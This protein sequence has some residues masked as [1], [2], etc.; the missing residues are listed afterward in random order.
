MSHNLTIQGI[1]IVKNKNIISLEEC[2]LDNK[3]LYVFRSKETSPKEGSHLSF[4]TSFALWTS[5][6]INTSTAVRSN[7]TSTILTSI[8]ADSCTQTRQDADYIEYFHIQLITEQHK[9]QLYWST[10]KQIFF[11]KYSTVL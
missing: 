7:T 3:K 1:D 6:S 11:Y 10:H 5:E 4:L 9:F 2:S 8:F